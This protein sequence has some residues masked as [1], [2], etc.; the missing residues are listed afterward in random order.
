M[1]ADVSVS[2]FNSYPVEFDVPEL[3]FDILLPGCDEGD[4]ILVAE[5]VTSEVHIQPQTRV[6]AD[7][8]GVIRELP[9]SLTRLCPHS[10]S[11]PLDLLLKSFMHGEPATM[12]V[13]GSSHPDGST[14][15]WIAE[16]LS[17]VTVPVP[18]PGRSL[19]GLIR[20]FAMTDTSFTMPDP[21]ADPGDPN[22]SPKFSGTIVVTAG[23][24][25]EMNFGI[26]VTNVRASADVF[27]KKKKLG[28]LNVRK[29]Q[30]ANSTRVEGKDG[31]EPTL[32]ITSRMNQ[33]PL[34]VTDSDVFTDVIS[35]LIFGGKQVNLD[36]KAAVDAK[37]VTKLGKLVV[38]EVPAEGKFPVKRPS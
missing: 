35:A 7:V 15:K 11:S 8:N 31:G 16:L 17:S 33:V 25:S 23:V 20:S 22:G 13:R 38:K 21:F 30:S 14:P 9:E 5:A 10:D 28:E 36:V 18:F 6:D 27:Y 32:R 4:L 24:P 29:W 12:F 2:A 34:N 37:V 1:L 26:D 3:A 19:D